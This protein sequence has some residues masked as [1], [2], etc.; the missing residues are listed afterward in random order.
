MAQI[1]GDNTRARTLT[2][3]PARIESTFLGVEDHGIFTA[4]LRFDF[5]GSVQGSPGYTLDDVPNEAGERQMTEQ[6]GEFIRRL[7]AVNGPFATWEN[8]KGSSVLVYRASDNWGAD[9]IGVGPMPFNGGRI[10]FFDEV[11]PA[12]KR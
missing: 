8:L 10:F 4:L 6:G 7:I 9:I 11:F 3:I 5:G 12:V 2:G 1:T